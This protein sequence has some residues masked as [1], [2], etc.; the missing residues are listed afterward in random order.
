MT[1][2]WQRRSSGPVQGQN[3]WRGIRGQSLTLLHTWP[4]INLLAVL[5]IYV[6]NMRKNQSACYT[7]MLAGMHPHA[8]IF[9]LFPVSAPWDRERLS[10]CCHRVPKKIQ[11]NKIKLIT[12]GYTELAVRISR[13]C[14]EDRS[15]GPTPLSEKYRYREASTFE[16][17]AASLP[18]L[19]SSLP[20]LL[21]L[22]C[23]LTLFSPGPRLWGMR[24][25]L[26]LPSGSWSGQVGPGRQTT[27]QKALLTTAMLVHVYEIIIIVFAL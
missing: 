3:P 7:N 21:P 1:G 19:P 15:D 20:S 27:M 25:R 23:P 10:F 14:V 5:Q 24:E 9:I 2:V 6:L 22:P 26:R 17:C 8:P 12:I 11:Q 18:S 4:S 13:P 16:N